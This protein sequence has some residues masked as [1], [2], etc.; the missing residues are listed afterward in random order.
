MKGEKKKQLSEAEEKLRKKKEAQEAEKLAILSKADEI[1]EETFDFDVDG[2]IE[3]RNEVSDMVLDAIDDP[4]EKHQLYYN[5]LNKM[6]RQ[7][8][9]KGDANK[10]ARDLIYEEKNTFLSGGHRK[11]KVGIRGAD[12]RMGYRTDM[13]EIINVVTE[14][15]ASRAGMFDLYIKLRAL[16]IEKGYGSSL[17]E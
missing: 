11:N 14:W 2:T 4:E 10:K 1:K 12:G 9:P 17:E 5:V 8:L 16:N 15:I 3:L 13:H 6:L 7:S